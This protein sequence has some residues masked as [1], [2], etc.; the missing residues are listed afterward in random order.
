VNWN[1]R[2]KHKTIYTTNTKKLNK[3]TGTTGTTIW[4]KERER[5]I[6]KGLNKGLDLSNFPQGPSQEHSNT[7]QT[8]KQELERREARN[9]INLSDRL[10]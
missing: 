2:L 5:K 10:M 4:V 9:T 1:N 6:E 3:K 8:S 7:A